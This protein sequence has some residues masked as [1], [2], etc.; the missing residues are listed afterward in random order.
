[1]NIH[2]YSLLLTMNNFWLEYVTLN[3]TRIFMIILEY[4]WIFLEAR[5]SR[6]QGMHLM[7]NTKIPVSLS[8][9]ILPIQSSILGSSMPYIIPLMTCLIHQLF[10]LLIGCG[11]RKQLRLTLRIQWRRWAF[12]LFTWIINLSRFQSV[13]TKYWVAN[14]HWIMTTKLQMTFVQYTDTL[15]TFIF[16]NYSFIE[17]QRHLWKR[18]HN[19]RILFYLTSNLRLLLMINCKAFKITV[20]IE[21]MFYTLAI[22]FL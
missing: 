10:L 15:K 8:T 20:K 7:A 18:K 6:K 2:D 9:L 13:Y 19:I 12:S 16:T 17:T 5:I 11:P 14:Q 4:P 22:Y 1:M 3:K 21:F